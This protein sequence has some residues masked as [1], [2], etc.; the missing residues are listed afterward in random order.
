MIH[1]AIG[2]HYTK[3]SF[4]Y[5]QL[6]LG[7]KITKQLSLLNPFSLSTNKNYRLKKIGFFAVF[8]FFTIRVTGENGEW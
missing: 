3:L 5:K 7:W 8:T 1:S 6:A 4:L 2:I